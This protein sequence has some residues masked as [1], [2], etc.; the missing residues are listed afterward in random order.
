M[1]EKPFHEAANVFPLLQG[2]QLKALADDIAENGLQE[3]IWLHED[4]TILDGRNRYRACKIAGV[5]PRFQTYEG[6]DPLGFVLS[7]NLHRRHL[8]S[9]QKAALAVDVEE[10]ERVAA[11]Q[12][13]L[14]A[15][16]NNAVTEKIPEQEKG[17]SREKAAQKVGTNPRY[18]S[19]AKRIKKDAPDVFERM[20]G[21]TY[22]S[23]S[24]AKDVAKLPP[25]QREEVHRAHE[26]KPQRRVRS[27][28]K[29]VKKR[30]KKKQREEKRREM[31]DLERAAQSEAA[32]TCEPDTWYRLGRH[33]LYCGDTT[34]DAF[35]DA[36]GSAD[37]GFAD[38]P[39]G[40]EKARW[41]QDF[42]WAHDVLTR[43]CTYSW[44]TP[45]I[46]NIWH[47]AQ[48]TPGLHYRWSVACWIKNGMTRGAIG[49]GNWLYAALFTK[50]DDTPVHRS[51][52]DHF[53]ITISTGTTHETDHPTR[54]PYE[55]VDRLL[56]YYAEDGSKIIDPFAGSGTTL[57][58]SEKRGYR[59]VAGEI[60]KEYCGE[61]IA[62]WQ[63]LT[64]QKAEVVNADAV[65]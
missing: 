55:F 23:M 34:D 2:E 31:I 13:Q 15:Q 49:F 51:A 39:Y 47:F 35:W 17:E 16:N 42:L 65:Q 27:I 44:V 19:D 1:S 28:V 52:Q 56:E 58:V 48:E 3:A 41:D 38:P 53:A 30:E 10:Y 32:V 62:R 50:A 14:A 7:L 59:C 54:K 37:V 9:A 33:Y 64:N 29:E 60:S 5:E 25:E 61:I 36:A 43:A 8:T 26:E 40:L 21:D 63:T 46:A 22:A 4:G 12:R 11:K 57:F 18:V 20:R 24:E 45:G 6:S